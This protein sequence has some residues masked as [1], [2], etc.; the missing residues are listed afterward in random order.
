MLKFLKWLFHFHYWKRISENQ[1]ICR[2]GCK[3]IDYGMV[4]DIIEP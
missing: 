3:L 1:Y 4:Q 2:C